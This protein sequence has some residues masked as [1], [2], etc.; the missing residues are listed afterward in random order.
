MDD[1]FEVQGHGTVQLHS[2]FKEKSI[3]AADKWSLIGAMFLWYEMGGGVSVGTLDTAKKWVEALS[4]NKSF[5]KQ[6]DNKSGIMAAIAKASLTI[7]K[8]KKTH[9]TQMRYPKRLRIH[10][11]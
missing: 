7:S 9:T 6:W 11:P 2:M 10:M 1:L 8:I 3:S 5:L 4:K